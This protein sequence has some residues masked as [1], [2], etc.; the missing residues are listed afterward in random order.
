MWFRSY[1][2]LYSYGRTFTPQTYLAWGWR[3]ILRSKL[4]VAIDN[5][6]TVVA[7][8]CL[9]LLF[10]FVLIGLWSLRR[11]RLYWPFLVYAPLLWLA[12]TV[13]FTYPGWRGGLF[14]SST[15]WLP[16]IFPAAML[17]LEQSIAWVARRRRTWDARQ[18]GLVFGTGVV[19]IAAMLSGQIYWQR[20]LGGSLADPAWNRSDL[21]Y[22]EVGDW[23][24]GHA[25]P[26]DLV[27]INNPPSFYYHTGRSSVAVPAE[28]PETLLEICDRYGVRFVVLDHNIV[29]ALIP[30]YEGQAVS[31]RLVE[32]A[33]LGE[34]PERP[35]I[36]YEVSEAQL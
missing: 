24:D 32:R 13:A 10:P 28:G 12:M 16:F 4:K 27:M 14:H 26:T 20:V 21:V 29:P 17:G 23:L 6:M 33:C 1:N 19:L 7:V 18:A 11:R 2:D 25:A 36:V 22:R 8:D 5:L 30:L 9:V 3:N 34:N 35:L 31:P 15:A